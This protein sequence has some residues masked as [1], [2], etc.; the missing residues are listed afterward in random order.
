MTL[1]FGT[2][3]NNGPENNVLTICFSAILVRKPRKA[4]KKHTID[5][6][7]SYNHGS[8]TTVAQS[9]ITTVSLP[10]VSV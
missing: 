10:S 9:E 7:V 6:N 8:L 2:I 3:K 5:I 4:K 1:D